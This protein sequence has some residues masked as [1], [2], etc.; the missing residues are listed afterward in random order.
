MINSISRSS[1]LSLHSGSNSA[2]TDGAF[3]PPG[4]GRVGSKEEAKAS[5]SQ[6]TAPSK[7]KDTAPNVYNTLALVVAGR[8]EKRLPTV[9]SS[10]ALPHGGFAQRQDPT[11]FAVAQV[12]GYTDFTIAMDLGHPQLFQ[13]LGEQAISFDNLGPVERKRVASA[14]Q[15]AGF[16]LSQMPGYDGLR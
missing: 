2:A 8:L 12:P 15:N 5:T 10:I 11:T 3:P 1:A 9:G 16:Q 13:G 14:A 4:R 6:N 7:I